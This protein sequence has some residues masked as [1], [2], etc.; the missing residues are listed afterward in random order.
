MS[1]TASPVL[2]PDA[3]DLVVEDPH[4]AEEDLTRERRKGEPAVRGSGLRKVYRRGF[5]AHGED[6]EEMEGEVEVEETGDADE[7]RV[8]VGEEI[9][10]AVG[11]DEDDENEGAAK[12]KHSQGSEWVS[13]QVEGVVARS[14][15]P[16]LHAQVKTYQY[17]DLAENDNPWA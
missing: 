15:T 14:G 11:D 10:H 5:V 4:A 2:P 3:V 17:D 1:A 13:N 12:P 6:G 9:T 16:P 8:E 7:R